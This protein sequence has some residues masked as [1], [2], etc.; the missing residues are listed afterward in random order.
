M[1]DQNTIQRII[2]EANVLDVVQDFVSLKKAGTN[3]KGLCPF[4]NEKTP[5]FIV[6]PAKGIFKCFGCGESGNAVGF[7]MKHEGFSYP[8]ALRYLA[9]KY[10][11]EIV[12][13]EETAEEVKQKNERESLRIVTSFAQRY[14]T[15]ILHN[16]EEGKAVGL[17][18][19][20]ERGF[21]DA[22]IR[23]FQL[24]YCL[25]RRND[26]T[27]SA[28]KNGYKLEFLV[29]SGLTIEKED[30]R[31]DR[32]WSR[33]IFPIHSVSG[34][35]IGFG[36]RTLRQDKKIAK[37]LNSP[38]S[39]IY[40]KSY[41]LYG[42]F[43][44]KNAIIKN[45]KCFLVEGYTDVLSFAQS[46]IKNVVASSGT[47]LTIEQIRLISRF[48]NNL[49]IIYDGDEAGIKASL[50]GIDLVLEQGINVKVV[51][52]P[53]NEDPDS[54]SKKYN[55]TELIKYISDNE[56]NF[57]S[58]K[59]QLLLDDAK[60]DPVKRAR[61]VTDIVRSIAIIPDSIVQAEYIKECS[62]LMNV[63]EEMLYSETGK[64]KMQ[65]IS[66]K[67]QGVK[68][69]HPA[70]SDDHQKEKSY[71]FQSG[72][73]EAVEREIVRILLNYGNH[74]FQVETDEDDNKRSVCVARFIIE[75]LQK[76]G[77][78]LN[79][80]LYGKILNEF[81]DILSNKSQ[82]LEYETENNEQPEPS[83]CEKFFINH[84]DNT[85]SQLSVELLTHKYFLSKIFEKSGS[86]VKT[87]KM[88]LHTLVTETINVFKCKKVE[89]ELKLI[90]SR[91]QEAQE[92][93]DNDEIMNL[94]QIRMKLDSIKKKIS[95]Q[96]GDRTIL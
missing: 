22:I 53:D 84:A 51:L 89:S 13:H 35:V 28:L 96:I 19:F 70:G 7:V 21:N 38:E 37:Y 31:F 4:H 48:T 79:N 55:S 2:D 27:R 56:K 62:R 69:L 83:K 42:L 39:D 17:S 11:I 60:N 92:A 50:R 86:H 90:N 8:E 65:N 10:N 25:N 63:K 88:L 64:M 54:F 32:F 94:L 66:G 67:T 43:F 33:V 49:T 52:L 57:I 46:G 45:D 23:E 68:R 36:G 77:L 6:S 58:F 87:E 18:Y 3:Y 20:K 40:H 81:V 82:L 1:I 47:S 5:S 14:F 74:T 9:K 93:Q 71:H 80:P 24:G 61:L 16:H 73:Y 12:E 85:V 29:K 30:S 59:T 44:A 26:F 91:I 72:T 76:D 34:S 41:I 75:E 78:E 15:G 95:A